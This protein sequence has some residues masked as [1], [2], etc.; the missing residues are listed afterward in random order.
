MMWDYFDSGNWLWMGGMMVLFWG[1]IIVL[2]VFAFRS[3]AG[4]KPNDQALEVLRRRFASGDI[5]QDEFEKTRK[6]LQ[7]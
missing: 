6:A 3:F 1:G 2:A 5:T 4:T 7:G